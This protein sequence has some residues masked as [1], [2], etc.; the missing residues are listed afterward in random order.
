M[1]PAKL[2]RKCSLSSQLMFLQER[3]KPGKIYQR[4]RKVILADSHMA[5]EIFS[6]FKDL[7]I[8]KYDLLPS[9]SGRRLQP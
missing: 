5:A 8:W 2:C 3:D 6:L 4:A 9:S 1:Q 7:F